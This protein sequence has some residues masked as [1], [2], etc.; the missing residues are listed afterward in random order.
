MKTMKK[1]CLCLICA[2]STFS[3]F[4]QNSS[5]VKV[6]DP[7]K[8]TV[9]IYGKVKIVYEGNREFYYKT[10]NVKPEVKKNPDCYQAPIP[11][12]ENQHKKSNQLPFLV[13]EGD[14]FYNYCWNMKNKVKYDGTFL[15]YLNKNP[16]D[17]KFDAST[18]SVLL[19]IRFVCNVPKDEKYLYLGTLV[20]YV[21][22]DDFQVTRIEILDEYDSAKKDFSK[23]QGN[24]KVLCR[25]LLETY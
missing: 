10:F 19:P 24:D 25:A 15:W 5:K 11:V 18:L 14:Y 13:E 23:V 3:V 22:G 8:G 16:K 20:Y 21:S 7:G 6:T 1:A 17:T 4:A 12:Y 2:L 9:V